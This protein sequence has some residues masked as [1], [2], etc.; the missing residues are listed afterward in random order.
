MEWINVILPIFTLIIGFVL[1]QFG[2]L[3]KERKEKKKKFK[4]L[5]FN[6]LRLHFV[7]KKEYE[8]EKFFKS[9]TDEVLLN[10]PDDL[11]EQATNDLI[12][13]SPKILNAIKKSNLSI[14]KVTYLEQNINVIIEEL[15]EIFPI[16]A[17]ELIEE[18]RIKE[19]LQQI[20]IYLNSM[21][22][23]TNE[24][25]PAE[26]NDWITLQVKRTAID[27]LGFY[28]KSASVS[29]NKKTKKAVNKILDDNST[30]IIIDEKILNEFI[31]EFNEKYNL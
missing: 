29:I 10:L 24:L 1:A 27:R 22:E 25:P 28:I 6:L 26:I 7:L 20:E 11:R 18:Y 23:A 2:E 13:S 12:N 14:E 4:K 15:A 9:Y 30:E 17:F 19:R 3:F 31:K 8:S 16:F 5:L 21:I